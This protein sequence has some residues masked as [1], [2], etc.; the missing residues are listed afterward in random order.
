MTMDSLVK[1]LVAYA[2]P[3]TTVIIVL[4]FRPH[5]I[6]LLR[7][8]KK[9]EL[10]GGVS[11]ETFSDD[12]KSAKELSAEV[13]AENEKKR[14]EHETRQDRSEDRAG[15]NASIPLTEVNARMLNLGMAPSPSGLELSFYRTLAER[16]PNL[17]L[18][19][20][21]ME[22]QLMLRNLAKGWKVVESPRDS[23]SAIVRK[24]MARNAITRRQ[25]E[26]LT[27]I[28]QLCNAAVHGLRVTET[29][30]EEIVNMA[31]ILRDQY[32]AWLSWGFADGW[33]A[34]GE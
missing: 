8:F 31:G 32:I 25:G 6:E 29:D 4:I 11:V 18:A 27:A 3:L 2:W 12:L 33:K 10:P 16:D 14:K 7:R 26:L 20:I 19:G 1:I 15:M 21:R 9:A 22:V 28:I 23:A 24:L 13:Q 17:A 30:V 34:K 5:I